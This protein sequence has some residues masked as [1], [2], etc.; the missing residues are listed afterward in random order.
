[1]YINIES[2]VICINIKGGNT[3]K[4][5]YALC[6]PIAEEL[7][8]YIWDIQYVKEGGTWYLRVLI[9]TDEGITINECEQFSRLISDKLD[10]TDP[11]KDSYMLEVSS[12][13]I[14]RQL[15]QH[16]HYDALMGSDVE[17]NLIRPINGQKL[18][19][20][21]LESKDDNGIKIIMSDDTEM[22]FSEKEAAWVRLYV[23]F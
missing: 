1:M 15:T 11:I 13:G 21:R 17:V 16:W 14:D 9:D 20:G 18:F 19:V 2:R 23:E 12:P 7:S 3:V 5:V 4:T 6:K 22:C 10:E 8:V